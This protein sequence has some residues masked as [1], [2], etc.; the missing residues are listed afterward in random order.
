L[1]PWA[2]FAFLGFAAG[3]AL[4]NGGRR[5][6][7]LRDWSAPTTPLRFMGRHALPIYLLHQLLLFPLAWLLAG[8]F[9]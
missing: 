3:L 1:A 7:S 2:G 4:Y 8:L 6:F 5:R 9:R